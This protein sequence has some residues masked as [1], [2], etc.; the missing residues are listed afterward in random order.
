MC[1]EYHLQH[2]TLNLHAFF[3]NR[4]FMLGFIRV[5]LK[6]FIHVSK[7][8]VKTGPI[9]LNWICMALIHQDAPICKDWPQHVWIV[10]FI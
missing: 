8:C 7:A 3:F 6:L 9:Q 2:K 4:K 1:F 5:E 10:N